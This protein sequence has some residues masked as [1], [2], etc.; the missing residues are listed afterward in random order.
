M[1]MS[2]PTFGVVFVTISQTH[3]QPHCGASQITIPTV[4]YITNDHRRYSVHPW[5]CDLIPTRDDGSIAIL[6]LTA[7][8]DGHSDL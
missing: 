4:V 1:P 6:G 3:D 2:G 5:A 7:D 8:L